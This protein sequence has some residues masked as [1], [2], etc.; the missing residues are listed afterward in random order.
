MTRRIVR[1][2]PWQAGKFAA[3]LY[4]I[5]GIVMAGVMALSIIFAPPNS[6][7]GEGPPGWGVV[8]AMPFLYAVGGIVFVPA[9]CW[10]YNL[11]AGWVGGIEVTVEDRRES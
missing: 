6:A 7:P 5:M 10:L 8:I 9:S 1:I 4:F 3:V 2:A 11:V